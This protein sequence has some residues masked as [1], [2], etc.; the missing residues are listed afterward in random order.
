MGS[1]RAADHGRG[2]IILLYSQTLCSQTLISVGDPAK[3]YFP[4][5]LDIHLSVISLNIFHYSYTTENT[6]GEVQ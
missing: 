3:K 6:G 1:Q 4:I 2:Q 5:K